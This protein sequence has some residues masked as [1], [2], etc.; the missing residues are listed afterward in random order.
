MD[1]NNRTLFYTESPL[2]ILSCLSLTKLSASKWLIHNR[3]NKTLQRSPL[4]FWFV[5]RLDRFLNKKKTQNHVKD[6]AIEIVV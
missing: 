4:F 5:N 6:A 1:G 2:N 3:Y